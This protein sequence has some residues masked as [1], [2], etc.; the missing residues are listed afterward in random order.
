MRTYLML[1]E[2]VLAFR[3][4]PRVISAMAES[5][6]PGLTEPTLAPGET[7]RDLARDSFDV[8]AA[9]KRGYHYEALDQL[10]LEHLMGAK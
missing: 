1:K 6:I 7:W 4:D 3:S 5:N 8:E 2:R 10:A 9:G